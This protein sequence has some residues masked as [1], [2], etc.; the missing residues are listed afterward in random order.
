M[1]KIKETK[2][3]SFQRF[4]DKKGGTAADFLWTLNKTIAAPPNTKDQVLF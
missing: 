4:V 2:N 1:K 3:Q